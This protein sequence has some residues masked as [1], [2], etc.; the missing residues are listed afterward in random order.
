MKSNS[1]SE[2]TLD[3]MAIRYLQAPQVKKVKERYVQDAKERIPQYFSPE[4]R[5]HAQAMTIEDIQQ[6]GL[7]IEIFW[8]MVEYNLNAKEGM[9]I[10]R[11]SNIDEHID[12]LASEYVVYHERIH[13]DFDGEDQKQQLT[14]LDN[15]FTRSFD[16]MVNYYINTVGKFFER[17]DIKDESAIMF[18]S[19]TELYLR[20]IHLYANFI[21]LEPDYA[22]VAHTEDQWLL[23]DSYFMGDVLRL[24]ISKLYPQCILM[25]TTM[26]TETELSLAGII[27]QS[28]NK[29]LITQ[30]ST[31]VSEEQ[32]GIELGLFAM[33]I[34]LILQKNDISNDLRHKITTVYSSFYNYKIADINKRQQ[35]ATENIYKLENDLYAAL[36]ENIVSHW[37]KKL[38][39]YVLNE[40]IA[41]VFVEGIPN[42]LSMFKQKVE[43]GNALERY[44]MNNEWFQFY[45]DSTTITYNHS[46]LFTYKL[47]LNDWN[48]FVEKVN[49]DLKWQYYSQPTL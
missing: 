32:L 5:M 15:V 31:A 17:N 47:R 29:W 4:K 1:D 48:D 24:I 7:P 10:N 25:P 6:Q 40:D 21:R 13:R 14:Q 26:Y 44:Q 37:T 3:R 30:K 12:Y 35:E 18:Q 39:Q 8:R 19:I 42:A 27:F 49:L 16:R 34:N 36:D 9:S 2:Q 28:A 22:Q 33:K 23:R 43:H 11:L 46:N 20:K 41:G 38:N 45:N